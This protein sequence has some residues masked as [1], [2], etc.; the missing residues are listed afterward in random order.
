MQNRPY[1]RG[2]FQSQFHDCLIGRHERLLLLVHAVAVSVFINC[3]GWY[4]CT[5]N[6]CDVCE[7][8]VYGKTQNLWLRYHGQCCLS[9]APDCSYISQGLD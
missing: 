1:G 6:V 7:F 4:A 9:L 5:E 8:S 3:R 2:I